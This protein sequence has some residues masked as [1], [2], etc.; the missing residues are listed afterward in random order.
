M[1]LA[2]LGGSKSVVADQ[3][4]MFKWPI[5]TGD[6]EAAAIDVLRKGLMSGIEITQK[7]EAKYAKWYGADYALACPNGT[8][9][10]LE[11]MYA[12][13]VKKGDEVICPSITFW[14]S[15]V[16]LYTLRA[17]PVF[18]D[19]DPET[20]NIDPADIERK[21]TPRTKAIMVVHYGGYPADMDS[22]MDIARRHKLK[23][24]EDCAHA[25]GT[26]YK[27][28]LA[29]TF[30]DVGMFSLM[31]GKAFAI[32]EGGILITNDREAYERALLWGHYIRHG[33][34]T[35]E[36]IKEFGGLPCGGAK[37]RLNQMVSA[38]GIVQIDKYPA[39]MVEI[40]KAMNYFCQGL[41]GL[42]GIDVMKL[43]EGSTKGGWYYPHFRYKTEELGGLSLKRFCGAIEAEGSIA[44]PGCN[45]PLHTHPLFIS[46]DVFGEGKPS[47][48]ANLDDAEGF[49]CKQS[50]PVSERINNEVFGI[51]WFKHF[52]KD[53]ID[54]HIAAY[55]KVID[56]YRE[57]LDGDDHNDI[58]FGGFSS[59][60]KKSK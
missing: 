59:F 18:A 60:F 42:P 52:R 35:I 26:L 15:V 24:I 41:D 50:L 6:H 9:T 34:L 27:G 2:L 39:Q 12:V 14:A 57:L 58:D 17:T 43:P 22:I 49:E 47:R 16:Q 56:S 44:A 13:G 8:S 5:I 4:D 21:I 46:M 23:V 31:T 53:I 29:G 38:I 40:D 1:D 10:I 48:I 11:A 45:K 20:M 25:H 19:I 28:K 7:F 32:G 54:E 55:K 51:P 33:N 36:G 37:N 3:G 30:G